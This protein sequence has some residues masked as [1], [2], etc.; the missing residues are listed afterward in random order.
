MN[1]T[2]IVAL[3]GA[4]ACAAPTL[5]EKPHRHDHVVKSP[6]KI[7]AALRWLNRAEYEAP[8]GG[9]VAVD[10]SFALTRPADRVEVR[11]FADDGLRLAKPSMA[12]AFE[13]VAAG[14]VDMPAVDVRVDQVGRRS[15]NAVVTILRHGQMTAASVSLPVSTPNA[16]P[17]E[18]VS[19]SL[20]TDVDGRAVRVMQATESQ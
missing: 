19:K 20:K 6:G 3:L 16:K 2:L 14:V 18:R 4:L 13:N 15:V 11:V 17:Q 10:F 8:A 5:A 12:F 9:T 1:K 7:G